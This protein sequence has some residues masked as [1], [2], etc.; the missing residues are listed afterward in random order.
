MKVVLTN[1]DLTGEIDDEHIDL[2]MRFN[3]S[4][5]K[6]GYIICGQKHLHKLIAV[7]LGLNG[8]IDHKDRDKLNCTNSNLRLSNQSQNIANSNTQ[9]KLK[10]SKYKGVCFHLQSN[11]W[12][13]SIMVNRQNIYLKLHESELEA[14]KAYDRAARHYFK[15]FAAVNFPDST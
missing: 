11:K 15:E 5:N 4:L 9:T 13:A 3:W 12:A 1:S 8:N 10:S 6:R 2:L 14:A 7:R